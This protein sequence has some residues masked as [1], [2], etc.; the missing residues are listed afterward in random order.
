MEKIFRSVSILLVAF[1]MMFYCEKN[2]TDGDDQQETGTVTDIDGNVYKTVKIGSQWW[3]AENLKVTHYRNGNPIPCVTDATE[4][5]N[6]TT[7]AYCNYNNEVAKT[8]DSR[9]GY[10]VATYGRLYNWYA[11]NDN[12]IIAP[13]GWHVPTDAEWQELIDYLGGDAVA[14]G[15][16]K[17]EETIHWVSPNTGATNGSGFTALPGGCRNSGGD[18]LGMGYFADFWSS[19]EYNTDCARSRY[20]H[21]SNAEVRRDYY[22]KLYGYSVRC[23]KGEVNTVTISGRVR[24]EHDLGISG[25]TL[26]LSNTGGTAT[27]DNSGYY[28]IT[29]FYGCSGTVTPSLADYSFSPT[30]RTYTNV[31]SDQSDQDYTGSPDTAGTVTDIDGNSYQ[32]IKIGTQWWMAENLKVTHYRNGEEIPHV[33]DNTDWGNLTAGACC[34]YGNDVNYSET[35]GRLYNWYAVDDSRGIAPAGWHVPSDQEWQALVDQLGGDATAGDGLKEAGNT[36]WTSLNTTATNASGFTA[37]PGGFRGFDGSYGGAGNYAYFWAST[38][39]NA[40]DA[41]QRQLSFSYSGVD[42]NASPKECGFSIRCVK[43]NVRSETR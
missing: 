30:N 14:G 27:T 28:S 39:Y 2:P 10:D 9:N 15:N 16:M 38:E 41:W 35:Y 5:A 42:H 7:G 20:L 3:M 43:D 13:T 36:H 34:I 37:L 25:V 31:T 18:F 17:E 33:T 1:F 29:V 6:L 19:T 11:V 23:V 26:T 22:D 21:C 8:S 40:S 4:W 12:R 24:T 32:T